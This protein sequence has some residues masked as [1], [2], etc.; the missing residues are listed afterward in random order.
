MN[1]AKARK[2]PMI[3]LRSTNIN[4][5]IANWPLPTTVMWLCI[6]NSRELRTFTLTSE[7]RVMQEQATSAVRVLAH[8]RVCADIQARAN[9]WPTCQARVAEYTDACEGV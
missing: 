7:D 8:T 1:R 5:D 3:R 4:S 2:G 9:F 6:V